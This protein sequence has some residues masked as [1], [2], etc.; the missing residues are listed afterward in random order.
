MRRKALAAAAAAVAL[1]GLALSGCGSPQTTSA[2]GRV[3][4]LAGDPAALVDPIDGTGVGSVSPGAIGEFPGADLPFGMIQWSPDT[5]PN[6][7]G[8]GGG[9]AYSDSHISGFSLT[10][11]SGTGCAAYG[12]VPILPTV[13]PIGPAPARTT[14]SFSHS[15]EQSAPGRYS[16]TLGPSPVR[17]DLA[18]TT[19]TGISQ[20][21]FPR[22]QEANVLFKVAGSANPVSDTS[23]YRVGA[24][25]IAGQVTSGDF[26]G[27][28]TNYTLYFE[29][30]F[31]RPFSSAGSW[32][33]STVSPGSTSCQGSA[34]GAFVTFDTQSNQVVLM[35]VGI[36][37]VSTA[38]AAANLSAEDPGWSLA[39]VESSA[40]AR[41]NGLL[42]RIRVGGGSTAQTRTFYTALYHSLLFP[43]VVSDVNGQYAGADGQ[44]HQSTTRTQY[45]N[46]SEWDIYRSEIELVS[47]LAPHQAGDMV[48]SLVNDAQQGGWLPKW[49]IVGGDSGQMNGDS[50]DPIIAAAYAFGIRDFD[51]PAALAAMVKGATQDETGHGFEIERQYLDQYL[52]QHYVN[53]ASLDLTSSN[54]SIGGS[55]T[56]EYA[57]DDFS[58]AQIALAQG[59]QSLYAD[60]MQRAHN[61]QYLFNPATGYVQGRS[62]DGS[63]PAGPAFQTSLLEPGGELGFEEGN[64]I[65]Y[66][67]SVPQDLS[68]L[69]SLMGGD[70]QAT[71]KL[72]TFF[73]VLNAG[74]DR[75]FDWAGNEPSLWT[76]WEYDYFGAPS[77]T[78]AVVRTIA[79]DLYSD[80]PVNEPGNDD[81]G[82]ISSWYVWAAMGMYPVT[83]GSADLALASPLFPDI[84]LAL[85]NGRRIVVHAPSAS[86]S[87]PYIHTLSITGADV[88]KT[89]PT[90]ASGTSP[91]PASSTTWDQPWL[92]SAILDTGGTLTFGLSSAPDPGWGSDPALSPPS[93]AWGR[94]P[95]V[96]Y[97]IPSG[98]VSIPAGQTRTLA[99]G[100]QPAAPEG[101]AVRWS[102]TGSPSGVTVS[103]AGGS[104]TLAA[105]TGKSGHPGLP[106]CTP[107]A[108]RTQNL[109]VGAT[110]PGS[111]VLDIHLETS[112]GTALPPVVVDVHVTG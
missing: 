24:D 47:L 54:Y 60:M 57:I 13:G 79:D 66:T 45:A 56:L 52:A 3:T 5:T 15:S 64:A 61:W 49:A 28:G 33:G 96:G 72:D 110:A 50:A 19:R 93:F 31:N 108:P 43:N 105:P 41:W 8:A 109:T 51:V 10:H 94:L 22:T 29:A 86:A 37:F 36:S 68:A 7:A 32:N 55:V 101:V 102:A 98:G 106:G 107:S 70:A 75:P 78:Q 73:T 1:V 2:P 27:T 95:A 91:S 38:N 80:T 83:P 53:A 59:D 71:K 42:S 69:S 6:R 4:A 74:R 89:T 87:T 104:L 17:T 62:A 21:T 9:Y 76:P 48:Q 112:D 11:L 23:V 63:F 16:V 81:L 18:V 84:S 46:F 100:I 77:R 34:C 44:V 103:P 82:A 35:K 88:P 65:Q 26:C 85:P 99:F 30:T 58:I 40:T 20:F 97:S 39:S 14:D 25:G 90:C 67:W 111:Y 92:P 12:D